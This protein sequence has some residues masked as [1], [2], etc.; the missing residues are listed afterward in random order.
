V[1]IE[2]PSGTTET[3]PAQDGVAFFAPAQ[4]GIYRYRIGDALH[5]IAVNVG[6]GGESDVAQRWKRGEAGPQAQAAGADAQ[7]MLPLWPYLLIAALLLLAFEW[8]L[9]SAGRRNA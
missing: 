3:L 6:D 1:A 8:W 7:A 2:R 5:R 9:W 4:A